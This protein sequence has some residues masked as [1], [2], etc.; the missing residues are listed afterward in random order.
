MDVLFSFG[1]AAKENPASRRDRLPVVVLNTT[2]IFIFIALIFV[3]TDIWNGNWQ[4]LFSV[5][6]IWSTIQFLRNRP[7]KQLRFGL[8]EGRFDLEAKQSQSYLYYIQIFSL[9]VLGL[10][11]LHASIGDF[12]SWMSGVLLPFIF[13]RYQLVRA[14]SIK[15]DRS[16]RYLGLGLFIS[17]ALGTIL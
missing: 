9:I 8:P 3:Q 17:G 2:F 11:L 14:N 13:T 12:G 7:L 1:H 5:L 4:W 16:I 15:G 6:A 10:I